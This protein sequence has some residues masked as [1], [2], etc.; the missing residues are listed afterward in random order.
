MFLFEIKE[1]TSTF[2]IQS[3][4]FNIPSTF[5]QYSLFIIPFLMK[6]FKVL[7]LIAIS[8]GIITSCRHDKGEAPVPDSG[9]PDAVAKILVDKCATAGCHNTQSKDGAS[10]LDLSTWD[11]ML[12]GNNSGAVVIPYNTECSMLLRFVNTDTLLGM[13]QIPTMPLN[14][15]QLTTSEYTTLRDWIA[16]GAPDKNGKVFFSPTAN[17]K[18]YYISNQTCDLIAVCDPV[19]RVIARYIQV[20]VIPNT[21]EQPHTI[22]MSPDG[23]YWYA[24]YYLGYV[25]QKFR[26]LDDS[27]VGTLTLPQSN[28]WSSMNFSPDSKTAYLSNLDN[29]G[30]AVVDLNSMTLVMPFTYPFDNA[31]GVAIN[32]N[33]GWLYVA[34]QGSGTIHKA[35]VTDLSSYDDIAVGARTHEIAFSPD[36]SKYFLTCDYDSQV[37]VMDALT[38][39]LIATIPTGTAPKEMSFSLKHPYLFVTCMETADGNYRGSVV[40]INYQ[41]NQKIK[42]IQNAFFQPHGLAVNDDDDVV[43]IASRNADPTGPAPHHLS[44]CGR[45]GFLSIIDME[46]LTVIPGYKNELSTDPYSVFYKK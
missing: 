15:P 10:G 13:V 41:T 23:N 2:N 3:S 43:Y 37:L 29:S 22:K 18:K 33:S 31:H 27:L 28:G 25:F 36:S 12:N 6:S 35:D 45:N 19:R 30:V 46:T 38:D 4:L 42:E 21:P 26:T 44:E 16:S 9:Y 39:V 32:P 7:L 20:G 14:A 1:K 40:V 8:I 5:L 24:V 11:K 17:Q 34:N